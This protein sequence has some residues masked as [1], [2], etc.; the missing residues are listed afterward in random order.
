M[1]LSTTICFQNLLKNNANGGGVV[2]WIG[3]KCYK[4]GNMKKL[5]SKLE[6]LSLKF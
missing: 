5:N 2:V 4:Q 3:F 6:N 1:N